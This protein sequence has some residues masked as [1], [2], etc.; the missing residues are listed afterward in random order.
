MFFS[1]L[2]KKTSPYPWCPFHLTRDIK[3]DMALNGGIEQ[4]T[5]TN[6]YFQ[7]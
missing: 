5:N 3:N 4:Q 1:M 7:T 2:K 6:S